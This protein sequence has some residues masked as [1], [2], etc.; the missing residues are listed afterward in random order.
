MQKRKKFI[1]RIHDFT[2]Q[3]IGKVLFTLLL[4]VIVTIPTVVL[5][6]LYKRNLTFKETVIHTWEKDY[7]VN[8]GFH[9]AMEIIAYTGL[10]L[11]PT[12]IAIGIMLFFK[13]TNNKQVLLRYIIITLFLIPT[14]ASVMVMAFITGEIG[15]NN[16]TS[17]KAVLITPSLKTYIDY[18]NLLQ[19][20]LPTIC[21]AFLDSALNDFV[22]AIK[23]KRSNQ[24][25]QQVLDNQ[26]ADRK[27]K[28][29]QKRDELNDETCQQ[30][31]DCLK[32]LNARD[33]D[34]IRNSVNEKIKEQKIKNIS[35]K[36]NKRRKI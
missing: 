30:L 5:E 28:K 31:F 10:L 27:L 1:R 26:I 15:T 18:F 16:T 13:Y 14:L 12:G 33:A 23:N 7:S 21:L 19:F 34:Y 32:D 17:D 2:N 29:Q 36:N 6:Q 20:V 25:K 3:G 8:Q 9:F 35:A 22:H 4:V 11:I 24:L